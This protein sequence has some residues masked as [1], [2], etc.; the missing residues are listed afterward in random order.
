[1]KVNVRERNIRKP[2]RDDN[3]WR[4]GHADAPLNHDA[5]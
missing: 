1:M 2:K 3:H 4:Y 5:H